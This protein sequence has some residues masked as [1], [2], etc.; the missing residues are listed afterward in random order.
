MQVNYYKEWNTKKNDFERLSPRSDITARSQ[1]LKLY[2]VIDANASYEKK[3]RYQ[4]FNL[5]F[6]FC[7]SSAATHGTVCAYELDWNYKKEFPIACFRLW[8]VIS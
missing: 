7:L 3:K 1:I 8:D 2:L 4:D 5:T 6:P